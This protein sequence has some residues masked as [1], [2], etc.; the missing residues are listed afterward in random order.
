MG[1]IVHKVLWFDRFALDLSRGCLRQGDRD[2]E[3]RPKTFEVLRHLAINAG[4]LVP[5]RDL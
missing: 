2:I 4:L 5:K 1:E 3:L